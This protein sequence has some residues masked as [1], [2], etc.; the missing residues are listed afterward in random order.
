[1]TDASPTAAA[2]KKPQLTQGQSFRA[3]PSNSMKK[4]APSPNGSPG[5]RDTALSLKFMPSQIDVEGGG[6]SS[7]VHNPSLGFSQR[8]E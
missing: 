5:R 6:D 1:M 4:G 7:Q 2:S 8:M 3:S